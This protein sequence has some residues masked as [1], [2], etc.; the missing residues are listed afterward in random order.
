MQVLSGVSLILWVISVVASEHHR[1]LNTWLVVMLALISASLLL[2]GRGEKQERERAEHA[3]AAARE[4]ALSAWLDSRYDE[5]RGRQADVGAVL[6]EPGGMDHA[7]WQRCE[8][9][10]TTLSDINREVA[11]R[12]QQDAPEWVHYFNSAPAWWTPVVPLGDD[13]PKQL[14][15]LMEFTAGQIVH[16]KKQLA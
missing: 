8:L 2:W 7:K 10:Q 6:A 5:V 4:D 15:R 12:L 3:L 1:P 9:A 13:F 14:I 16:I 11:R